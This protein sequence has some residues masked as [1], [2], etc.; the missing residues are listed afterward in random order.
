MAI[1]TRLHVGERCTSPC[2][3]ARPSRST[4][5][6]SAP[7]LLGGVCQSVMVSVVQLS[8]GGCRPPGI[9][10]CLANLA[11]RQGH[12]LL[13]LLPPTQNAVAVDGDLLVHPA[14][15]DQGSDEVQR[16]TGGRDHRSSST[17]DASLVA[18]RLIRSTDSPRR[19]AFASS[20]ERKR[21]TP[22]RTGRGHSLNA[23]CQSARMRAGSSSPQ[24]R[25]IR[26]ISSTDLNRRTPMARQSSSPRSKAAR[27][28]SASAWSMGRT[29]PRFIR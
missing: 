17:P 16:A 1:C 12:G 20:M 15:R 25:C 6:A 27:S 8:D 7:G 13:G 9:G 18:L 22:G 23:R 24:T 19:S 5:S 21:L 3:S 4:S 26:G 10:V 11:R 28:A 2:P 14:Q 29:V